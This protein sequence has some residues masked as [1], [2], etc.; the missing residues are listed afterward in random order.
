[1]FCQLDDVAGL[2]K[3]DDVGVTA[4]DAACGAGGV[5]KNFVKGFAVPP[6]ARLCGVGTCDARFQVKALKVFLN[7]GGAHGV[8]F[9]RGD[10]AVRHFQKV[11]RLAARSRAGIEN[12]LACLGGDKVC[13]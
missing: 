12:A 10:V 8:D 2:P 9:E 11:R 13:R 4:C 6:G 3:E 7:A 1:M 5:K